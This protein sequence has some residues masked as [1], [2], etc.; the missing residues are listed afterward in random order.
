MSKLRLA[1]TKLCTRCCYHGGFGSQPGKEQKKA[2][3]C[4]NISCNYLEITGHSR[5]NTPDGFAYDPK[6]CD[7]F[8][9]GEVISIK[10]T[11]D[12]MTM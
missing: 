3:Y 5:V 7:K 1:N 4:R 10:W 6:Y 12:S 8:R 11:S 2:G 9:E